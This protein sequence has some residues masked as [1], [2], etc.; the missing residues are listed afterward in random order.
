M[1]E[2]VKLMVTLALIV[3]AL[4]ASPLAVGETY[5]LPVIVRG[6]PGLNGSYWDSEARIMQLNMAELVTVKR[7]WVATAAGGFVDDPATAPSWALPAFGLQ[8]SLAILTGN[9]LL[10]GVDATHASVALDV[11]GRAA[12]IVHNTNTNGAGRLPP[13]YCCLPGN[14]QLTSAL[15]VPIQ[16][17]SIIP[18]ATS[19][20]NVFRVNVGIINP[21]TV[22]ATFR[23]KGESFRRDGPNN[24][25]FW[26]PYGPIIWPGPD[27]VLPPLGWLQVNDIFAL[28]VDMSTPG[29]GFPIEDVLPGSVIIEPQGDLPYYAY[30]T[31]IYSP[32]NDPEF[33]TAIPFTP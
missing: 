21:N 7:V 27:V 24:N 8:R 33:I 17:P 1:S 31:P 11:Q 18:W 19:G 25:P 26:R 9:D 15:T 32:L 10:Q 23:L 16:G 29:W 2:R 4:A 28:F 22:S 12:V 30:A 3:A 6:V 13:E 14:G 5:V 20:R